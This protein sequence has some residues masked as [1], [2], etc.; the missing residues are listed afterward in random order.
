MSF[1]LACPTGCGMQVDAPMRLV[2]EDG[3]LLRLLIHAEPLAVREGLRAVMAAPILSPLPAEV[4][5]RAQIV[6]AE[7]LNNIAEHAYAG[8]GGRI[9]LTV[10]LL[11]GRLIFR[12][13][14]D[15]RPM[16]GGA[17]PAGLPVDMEGEL[18]EGGF[19]WHLIRSM[20]VRL[21]YLRTGGANLL[22]FEIPL[23]S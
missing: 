11:P 18:P 6:L 15:G 14:D 22:C 19:G 2:A 9:D 3:G 13:E 23:R 20:A 21:S 10:Q 17:L 8:A 4:L 12:I 7:V 5:D 16:P 1:T